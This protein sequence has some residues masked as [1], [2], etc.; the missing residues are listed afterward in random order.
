MISETV[1]SDGRRRS[2]LRT[3]P[4][5]DGI[6]TTYL[7]KQLELAIRSEMDLMTRNFDLTPTQF[8]ALTVLQRNPG[9]SSAQLARRSFVSAQAGGEMIAVLE[10]K[11]FI[12]R[13]SDQNNRRILRINLTEAGE[14]LLC[15][16]D[17]R[18]QGIEARMLST[19]T[20]AEKT[21]FGLALSDCV[22]S[23][24]PEAAGE[25]GRPA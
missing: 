21:A 19:L 23:L 22:R 2:G 4:T 9:M 13:Q 11:G 20:M 16:C 6:R 14:E 7:V 15:R 10:R 18:M 5:V 17:A 12:N 24:K 25:S 1:E 8:T 3:Q